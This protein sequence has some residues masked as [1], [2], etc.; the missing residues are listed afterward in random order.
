MDDLASDDQV[1]RMASRVLRRIELRRARRRALVGVV[2]T[3]LVLA[4]GLGLLSTQLRTSVAAS[5]AGGSTAQRQ[6][7]PVAGT[8]SAVVCHGGPT[9]ASRSSTVTV[10][11]APT[12]RSA[13]QACAALRLAQRRA[14]PGSAA[15][16]PATPPTGSDLL[17]C[18]DDAGRLQVFVKDAHPATLCVRNGM[19][20]P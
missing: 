3:V 19:Q 16:A 11:G 9:R 6:A 4:G 17:V 1:A 8:P 14:G 15:A 10:R 20:Q 18:R 12:A 7:G 5:G 13:T 2:A